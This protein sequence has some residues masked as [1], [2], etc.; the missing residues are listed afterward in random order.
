MGRIF[1]AFFIGVYGVFVSIFMKKG[2]RWV[3]FFC[4]GFVCGRGKYIILKIK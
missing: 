4:V 1:F 2:G 3:V